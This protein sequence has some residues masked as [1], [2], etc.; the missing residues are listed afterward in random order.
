MIEFGQSGSK[1]NESS[2]KNYF[3]DTVKIVDAKLHYNETQSFRKFPD[4]LGVT[5][6]L[7]IGKDFNPTWYLGGS[8]KI[9]DVSGEITGWKTVWSGVGMLFRAVGMYFKCP[10]GQT[11]QSAVFSG[12]TEQKLI[13]REF[14]RLK[15]RSN[16]RMDKEG[17]PKWVEFNNTEA[18][19]KE[20]ELEKKFLDDIASGYVKDFLDPD[21]EDKHPLAGKDEAPFSDADLPV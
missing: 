9:D 7:D 6:T 21:S 15:Y 5:L 13:G 8:Y 19:G 11:P 17:N 10:T 12:E 16:S 2:G 20:S 1:S 14:C 3:I 4:H 18:I